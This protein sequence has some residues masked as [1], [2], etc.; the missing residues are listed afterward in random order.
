MSGALW[1]SLGGGLFLMSKVP[2]YRC[3]SLFLMS[4]VP[5]Y[6]FLMSEVP[7]YRFSWAVG[8]FLAGV[9]LT[10]TS[11]RLEIEQVAATFNPLL[12]A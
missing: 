2:L 6:L 9:T 3:T 11:K 8:A 10:F 7:L 12:K 5:L 4:E 1:W